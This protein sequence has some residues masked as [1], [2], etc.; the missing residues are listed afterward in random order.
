MT[1]T[2]LDICSLVFAMTDCHPDDVDDVFCRLVHSVS[3]HQAKL[4]GVGLL[5]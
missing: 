5:G 4:V 3:L 2:A 1:C